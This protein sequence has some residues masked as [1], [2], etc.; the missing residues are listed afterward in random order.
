MMKIII[1]AYIMAVLFIS[2]MVKA[3]SFGAKGR[4]LIRSAE[5]SSTGILDIDGVL[6]TPCQQ[7]PSI[8]VDKIDEANRSLSLLVQTQVRNGVCPDVLAKNFR[9]VFDMKS[10]PLRVG[11]TYNVTLENSSNSRN[12]ISYKAV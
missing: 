4:G 1:L 9:I 12:I 11:V 6:T 2:G 8:A 5:I 7:R 3:D 10:L